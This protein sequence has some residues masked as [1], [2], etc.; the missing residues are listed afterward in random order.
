[1]SDR[2]GDIGVAVWI[3]LRRAHQGGVANLAGQWFD[4]GSPVPGYVA[5]ALDRLTSAGQLALADPDPEFCG[6]RRVTVTDTGCAR[7]VTLCQVHNPRGR[8]AVSTPRRWARSPH[9]QRSH[10]LTERGTDQIGV[11]VG[12]CGHRMLWS[13]PTSAQPTGQPCPTCEALPGVPVGAP[14]FGNPPDSGRPPVERPPRSVPAP[15]GWPD[16]T[17][18]VESARLAADADRGDRPP[19]GY[20]QRPTKT[21][22]GRRSSS[23]APLPSRGGQPD[24]S[25][26]A[27]EPSVGQLRWAHC[28]NDR[29][30][31]LLQPADVIAVA[32]GHAEALCGTALL[33]EGLTLIHGSSGALCLSCIVRIRPHLVRVLEGC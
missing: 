17:E 25:H 19:G 33:A 18:P 10:L 2:V 32:A 24:P 5:D 13:V 27:G 21:P 3:A 6:A 31:H 14:Q 4:S 1:M 29:R 12:V 28:P 16:T 26:Q 9:D 7:Y 11:L 22:A 23:P 15:G 8:A 30:L 20:E